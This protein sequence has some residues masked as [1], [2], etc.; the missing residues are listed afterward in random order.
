MNKENLTITVKTL[1]TI[2]G[3][4]G[5]ALTYDEMMIL[6]KAYKMVKDIEKHW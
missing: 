3:E 5:L 6:Q 4:F 2:L 1:K